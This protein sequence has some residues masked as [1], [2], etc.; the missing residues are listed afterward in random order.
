MGRQVCETT[1]RTSV[2]NLRYLYED[3]FATDYHLAKEIHSLTF[4][5]KSNNTFG[6]VLVS[7]NDTSEKLN[8]VALFLFEVFVQL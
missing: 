7:P 3:S 8:V 4:L 1:L 2:E 5:S 6:I